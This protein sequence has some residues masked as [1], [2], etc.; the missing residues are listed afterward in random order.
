M[1]TSELSYAELERRANQ[2]AHR[3]GELGVG[4][5]VSVAVCLERSVDVVVALLGVLKA[6]G[7][8]VPIDPGYPA[9]RQALMRSD[10]DARVLICHQ[11]LAPDDREGVLVLDQE[12]AA[13]P[14]Y[15][16]EAPALDHDPEQLAYIIYTSGSTGTPKGVE[17][18]HRSL[19]NFLWAMQRPA[20]DWGPRTCS[21]R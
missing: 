20:R 13:L 15:P 6:G 16:T 9:A 2:L 21:S 18:T 12:G 19:V 17:I 4:P 7:A 8:Y 11:R 14:R 10:S 5:E 3:L 1:V